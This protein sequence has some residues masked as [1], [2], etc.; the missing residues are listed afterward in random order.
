MWGVDG[1]AALGAMN[2][3]LVSRCGRAVGVNGDVWGRLWCSW[4]GLGSKW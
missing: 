4:R 1:G 3:G 2:V